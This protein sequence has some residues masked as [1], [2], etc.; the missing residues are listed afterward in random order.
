MTVTTVDH[1]PSLP[2]APTTTVPGFVSSPGREPAAGDERARALAEGQPITPAPDLDASARYA[3]M[4]YEITGWET[5]AYAALA[6]SETPEEA[7]EHR[8]I[9]RR[10]RPSWVD[11]D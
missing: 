7:E 4:L 9:L 10:R 5:F 3:V 2:E 6:A 8:R 1:A 11:E